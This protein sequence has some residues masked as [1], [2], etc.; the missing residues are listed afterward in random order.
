LLRKLDET[1]LVFAG[2]WHCAPDSVFDETRLEEAE[3]F[4]EKEKRELPT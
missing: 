2:T 1:G 3:F 4:A